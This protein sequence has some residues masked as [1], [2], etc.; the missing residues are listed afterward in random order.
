MSG[1]DGFARADVDTSIYDD[2]KVRALARRL[3][4]HVRTASAMTL[5][6]A[7]MLAS[8][9]A[10]R[11]LTIDESAPAW[12]LDDPSDYLVDLQAV[13]LLDGEGR[14]PEHAFEAWAGRLIDRREAAA[15]AG[16]EGAR[17]RWHPDEPPDPMGSDSG[18]DGG[19]MGPSMHQP[20]SLPASRPARQPAGLAD[21]ARAREAPTPPADAEA[22]AA[23]APEL[24][25]DVLVDEP[26]WWPRNAPKPT[27]HV[28]AVANVALIRSQGVRAGDGRRKRAEALERELAPSNGS[29]P[30]AQV[31][32]AARQVGRRPDGSIWCHDFVAHQLA[33]RDVST[34][35]RCDLEEVQ[36]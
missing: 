7:T 26:P 1:R 14:V 30:P 31:N 8:W 6:Q 35:P 2:P 29:P 13:Q 4:D 20:A 18:P 24:G 28:G 34:N 17:R 16:R 3:R 9:R 33:H 12:W 25:N 23:P 22:P 15:D 10:G 11:R 36:L 19:A 27:T 5:Y 21:V 32:G